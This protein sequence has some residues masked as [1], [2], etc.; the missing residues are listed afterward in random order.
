MSTA[1]ELDISKDYLIV[2]RLYEEYSETCSQIAKELEQAI[3]IHFD[4]EDGWSVFIHGKYIEIAR[5][6]WK[7]TKGNIFVE[8]SFLNEDLYSL[9]YKK[10]KVAFAAYAIKYIEQSRHI[11]EY[12]FGRDK[13]CV[14]DIVNRLIE[15]VN[16]YA[17]VME[18]I[19]VK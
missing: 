18:D 10:V 19:A 2:N 17:S 5:Q 1:N 4:E 3:T 6:N 15:C 11:V 13:S 8:L 14:V 12:D 9:A 16:K 7:K